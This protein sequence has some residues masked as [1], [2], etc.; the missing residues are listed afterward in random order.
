MPP[1]QLLQFL[2]FRRTEFLGDKENCNP[3]FQSR[4]HYHVKAYE[5]HVKAYETFYAFDGSAEFQVGE[6]LFSR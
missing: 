6:E 1:S 4:L 2:L 3:G 5:N